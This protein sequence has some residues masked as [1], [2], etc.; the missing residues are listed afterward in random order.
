LE[1]SPETAGG[2]LHIRILDRSRRGD[3][4]SGEAAELVRR[5]AKN[6]GAAVE[7]E[8]LKSA[9][10]MDR[11]RAAFASTRD[12]IRLQWDVVAHVWNRHGLLGSYVHDGK[13][14]QQ[15]A[16]ALEILSSIEPASASDAH[17]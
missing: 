13:H 9:I 7:P 12:G 6:Q 3:V 1:F 2:A 8:S 17:I 14:E 5:F 15:R 16:E 11:A 4:R 10:G